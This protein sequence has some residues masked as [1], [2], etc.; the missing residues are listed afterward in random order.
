ME[1]SASRLGNLALDAVPGWDQPGAMPI[2]KS[3][4][5]STSTCTGTGITRSR[6]QPVALS[7]DAPA[8]PDFVTCQAVVTVKGKPGRCDQPATAVRLS[9]SGGRPVCLKHDRAVWIDYVKA[10]LP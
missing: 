1:S 9:A 6:S 4:T 10:G 5:A 7:V 3:V 2:L 8:S